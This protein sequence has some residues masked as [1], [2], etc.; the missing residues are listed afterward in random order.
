MVIALLFLTTLVVVSGTKWL[1]VF[2]HNAGSVELSSALLKGDTHRLQAA[3][4]RFW[5]ALRWDKNG[6]QVYHGLG[7]IYE[8]QGHY[9]AAVGALS[10]SAELYSDSAIVHFQLG[11]VYEL[12]G[13][14]EE[15]LTE[16]RKVR[17]DLYFLNAARTHTETGDFQE[18]LINYRMVTSINPGSAAAYVGLGDVYWHYERWDEAIAAYQK[19]IELGLDE[20]Q[21]E[22]VVAAHM[23]AGGMLWLQHRWEDAKWHYKAAVELDRRNA[24]GYT[25]L[26]VVHFNLGN[27]DSAEEA[28]RTAISIRDYY[29]ARFGLGS[30]HFERGEYEQALEQFQLASGLRADAPEPHIRLGETYLQMGRAQDAIAEYQKAVLLGPEVGRHYLLLGDAYR[31]IG[32]LTSAKQTYE[33]GLRVSPDSRELKE[34]LTE[35]QP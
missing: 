3:E 10:R 9:P 26:G 14:R 1:S 20:Q 23:K 24:S 17:A 35:A 21:T 8:A 7:R 34:R 18:A 11:N 15:A 27:L 22:L 2:Y 30:V 4:N 31:S 28:Y 19:A 29:W 32:D 13:E 25:M 33:D 6:A 5:R 12:M 16:W